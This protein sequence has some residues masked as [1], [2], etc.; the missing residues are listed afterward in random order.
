MARRSWA[1]VRSA[2]GGVTAASVG[3]SETRRS[4][5]PCAAMASKKTVYDAAVVLD[6]YYY[7]YYFRFY[8]SISSGF[9]TRTKTHSLSVVASSARAPSVRA[10]VSA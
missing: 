8:F 5:R 9:R 6:L 2:C 7:Y 4:A 3:S 10:I 1:C